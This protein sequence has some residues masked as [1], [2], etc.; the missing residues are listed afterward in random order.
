MHYWGMHGYWGFSQVLPWVL[1][2]TFMMPIRWSIY[3]L[4]QS[5]SQLLQRDMQPGRSQAANTKNVGPYCCAM[6]IRNRDN[7]PGG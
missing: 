2:F 5:H 3:Q 6:L 7:H 4:L 1:F